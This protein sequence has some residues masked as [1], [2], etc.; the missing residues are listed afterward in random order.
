MKRTTEVIIERDELLVVR[1]RGSRAP[2]WC[3]ACGAAELVTPEEAALLAGVATRTLYRFVEAGLVH[4]R[5][6]P[7]GFLLVCLRSLLE[8]A[9]PPRAPAVKEEP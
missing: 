4:F 6:T 8:A 2:G 9:R 5:E 3:E 1:R 7:E